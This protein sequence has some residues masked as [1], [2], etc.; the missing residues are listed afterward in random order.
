MTTQFAHPSGS[1]PTDQDPVRRLRLRSADPEEAA[2]L[3]RT[4]YSDHTQ[5]FAGPRNGFRFALTSESIDSSAGRVTIDRVRHS[6]RM[7]VLQEPVPAPTVAVPLAGRL[8]L[9]SGR[10]ESAGGPVLL[11]ATARFRTEWDDVDVAVGTLDAAGV[12]RV[13]A[14]LS[15]LDPAEIAFTG[16][17]PISSDHARYIRALLGHLGRDVLGNDDVMASPL[18]RAE[19]QHRL[20]I[21]LLVAFPNTSQYADPPQHT[22]AQ[23]ATVRRAVEYIDSH[24]TEDIGLT[25]IAE[26]ARLSPRG[27]QHAFRQHLNSTPLAYLRRVRLEGAHRDLQAAD[28]TRGDTVATIAARWGFT[29]AGRFSVLYRQSYGRSPGRTLRS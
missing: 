26:A 28:P 2:H 18:A 7:G 29:H 12:R 23:P 24:A 10:D 3:L 16:L 4:R 15:G 25:E 8:R 6:M 20:A 13:G 17:N 14:E 22:G 21:G 27:L 9:V 11:P 1:G 19:A 5:L